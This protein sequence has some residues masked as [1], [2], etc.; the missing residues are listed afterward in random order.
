MC[1]IGIKPKEDRRF[2]SHLAARVTSA[3]ANVAIDHAH[4][5]GIKGVSGQNVGNHIATPLVS[6]L[7]NLASYI[8]SLSCLL[9]F[10]IPSSFFYPT[11]DRC[12][13]AGSAAFAYNR[14]SYLLEP[15]CCCSTVRRAIVTFFFLAR[16]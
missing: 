1:Y 16:R 15:S 10:F 14:H 7:I 12:M 13:R 4:F 5:S 9:F 3:P 8:P 6:V 2:I 11:H